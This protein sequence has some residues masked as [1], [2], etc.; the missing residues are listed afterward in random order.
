MF[1]AI[2]V[3]ALGTHAY[4][5]YLK[6]PPAKR[7]AG[8]AGAFRELR[9]TLSNRSFLAL[10]CASIFGAMAAGLIAALAIYINTYFW[11]LSSSQISVL[12]LG[13]FVSAVLA[14]AI[15][16]GCRAGSARSRPRSSPR[17]PP[18]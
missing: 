15:A 13:Y 5:P 17:S 2:L 4:I 16:P 10:F 7:R 11:E 6:H 8:L 9:E 14:V 3:S 12:V 18:S 1:A